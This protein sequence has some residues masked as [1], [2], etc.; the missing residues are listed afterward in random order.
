MWS[1]ASRSS[2]CASEKLHA[3]FS[4]SGARLRPAAFLTLVEA[5]L[6][7]AKRLSGG[8][9]RDPFGHKVAPN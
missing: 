3:S 6:D 7:P 5:I 1:S 9:R 8:G 2:P 4:A